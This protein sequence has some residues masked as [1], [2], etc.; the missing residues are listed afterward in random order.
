M[1]ITFDEQIWIKEYLNNIEIVDKSSTLFRYPFKDDFLKE[2]GSDFLNICEMGNSFLNAYAILDMEYCGTVDE[3]IIDIST[4]RS[5]KFLIFARHGFGNCY[6]WDSPWGDGF[7]KQVEGYSEVAEFIYS[8]YKEEKKDE[9]IFPMFFL[10]RN[11][12]ELSLK[13][14]LYV[15][16]TKGVEQKWIR[17]TRNTHSLKELWNA[18]SR[19]VR[20]YANEHGEDLQYLGYLEKALLELNC[21]DKQGD[22][23]RYPFNYNLSY[24]FDGQQIDVDNVFDFMAGVFNILDGCSCMLSEIAD[25]EAEMLYEM[26]SYVW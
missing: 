3:T 7:H 14:L 25:N 17:K 16:V 1:N 10:L 6:L 15:N 2:Y 12:V 5:D 22:V 13:R 21:I 4:E 20:S 26:Q 8:K 9:Y 11:A 19:M 23:F 18:V 24:R